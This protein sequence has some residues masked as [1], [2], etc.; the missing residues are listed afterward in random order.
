MIGERGIKRGNEGMIEAARYKEAKELRIGKGKNGYGLRY[1]YD[2]NRAVQ[3]GDKFDNNLYYIIS[4]IRIISI[5]I[6]VVCKCKKYVGV[7]L[8]L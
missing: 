8:P 4:N 2:C 3:M 1:G 6:F 5:A 7:S